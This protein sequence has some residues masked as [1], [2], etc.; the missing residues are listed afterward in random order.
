MHLHLLGTK[1]T[2]VDGVELILLCNHSIIAILAI[3][4]AVPKLGIRAGSLK[5]LSATDSARSW[6]EY[7]IGPLLN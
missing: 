1:L 2:Q 7:G 6:V 5:K 4:C 3:S